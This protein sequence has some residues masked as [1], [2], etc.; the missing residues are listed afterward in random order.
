MRISD[1]T[2]DIQPW[3]RV[4]LLLNFAAE[5]SAGPCWWCMAVVF[6]RLGGGWGRLWGRRW[7]G[8]RPHSPQ[9]AHSALLTCSSSTQYY[10]AQT[11]YSTL[12]HLSCDFGTTLKLILFMKSTNQ[13]WYSEPPYCVAKPQ[14]CKVSQSEAEKQQQEQQQVDKKYNANNLKAAAE[15][16]Y[17]RWGVLRIK[18]RLVGRII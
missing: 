10:S 5:H 2:F 8:R 14:D 11:Y 16:A 18:K 17:E 6:V 15:T 3:R 13:Q 4:N 7:V 12:Q 1:P 9:R